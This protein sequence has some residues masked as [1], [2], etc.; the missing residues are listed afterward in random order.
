MAE[1]LPLFPR[2]LPVPAPSLH[3]EVTA[4]GALSGR[5]VTALAADGIAVYTNGIRGTAPVRIVA[6][7]LGQPVTVGAPEEAA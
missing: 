3:V 5:I 6:E 2:S 7:D 1:V 4:T